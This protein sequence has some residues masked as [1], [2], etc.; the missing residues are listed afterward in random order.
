MPS[1]MESERGRGR[2]AAS[3]NPPLS[4]PAC[5][6]GLRAV[7]RPV[8]VGTSWAAALTCPY[9][10]YAQGRKG[11]RTAAA[12]EGRRREREDEREEEKPEQG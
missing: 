11:K 6:L 1:E 3:G 5:R 12:Q 4:H 9:K 7:R 10:P 2:R 8:D